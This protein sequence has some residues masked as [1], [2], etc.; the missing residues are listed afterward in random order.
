LSATTGRQLLPLP[1][2][3]LGVLILILASV[4][5]LVGARPAG[6]EKDAETCGGSS[7]NIPLL[8]KRGYFDT[9]SRRRERI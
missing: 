6:Q 1:L 5:L 8:E 7:P 4:G 2:H 3:R 9:A